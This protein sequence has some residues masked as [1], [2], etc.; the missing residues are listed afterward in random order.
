MRI[1]FICIFVFLQFQ[2]NG[3]L[4]YAADYTNSQLFKVTIRENNEE[5]QYEFENPSH[6]EWEKGTKVVKG[7][8]AEKEVEAL[9]HQL[10]ISKKAKVNEIKASLEN[11]GFT[12]MEHFVVRWI[13]Q[14]GLLYTW[15][16]E[17]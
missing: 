3:S 7:E 16:W 1:L 11:Y 13:D 4:T 17:E 10:G 12:N 2:F 15:H 6:Y 8:E 5:I 9:Y 14:D